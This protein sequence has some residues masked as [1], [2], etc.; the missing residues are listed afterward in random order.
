MPA[1]SQKSG[2][3]PKPKP[4]PKQKPKSEKAKTWRSAEAAFGGQIPATEP[5]SNDKAERYK[6][7][8]LGRPTLYDPDWMLPKIIEVGIRGGSFL[9]IA[10]S[11]GVTPKT[12]Y[13]W[14]EEYPEFCHTLEM[15]R[16]L[17]QEWWE[18]Q[19]QLGTFGAIDGY[20]ASSYTFQMKNRFPRDWKDSKQTEIMGEGGGPVHVEEQRTLNVRA[21]EPEQRERLKQLLLEARASESDDG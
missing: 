18:A 14:A 3:K 11:I 15:A 19:G 10:V 17:S 13:R 1:A 21:L 5:G 16:V 2:A 8:V 7:I 6:A 4:K 9:Q 20:N 12:I